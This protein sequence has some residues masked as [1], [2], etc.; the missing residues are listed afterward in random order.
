MDAVKSFSTEVT[1]SVIIIGVCAVA[2]LALAVIASVFKG[3]NNAVIRFANFEINIFPF[4]NKALYFFATLLAVL[5]AVINLIDGAIAEGIA[6]LVGGPIVVRVAFELLNVVFGIH[7]RLADINRNI[8]NIS[9]EAPAPQI[10]SAPAAD[11]APA[12]APRPA[13]TPAPKPAPQQKPKPEPKPAGPV[14][15]FCPNCGKGIKP[16]APFCNNCGSKL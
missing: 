8:Q 7:G 12:P 3:R 16:G 5:L 6:L 15:S 14:F 13:P 10:V 2:A 1:F 4:I 11:P 9:I